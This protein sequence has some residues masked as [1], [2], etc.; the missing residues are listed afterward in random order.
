MKKR[1]N[2]VGPAA[3]EHN[4]RVVQR[5]GGWDWPHKWLRASGRSWFY[6]NHTAFTVGFRIVATKRSRER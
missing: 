1:R 6:P 2:P 4:H 3:C 5:G